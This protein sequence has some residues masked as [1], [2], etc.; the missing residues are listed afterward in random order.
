MMMMMILLLCPIIF[1]SVLFSR[2]Q[3][4]W[5][6]GMI[7]PSP[8]GLPLI[9]NLHQ[10]G[11]HTHRSLCSLSHRYGPLML[12]HLGS[13]PVLIVSSAEMAKEVL[14]THDV[15]FANRPRSK[16]SEKLLYN[17][18]DVASAPYGEYWRQMKRVCVIHLLSKKMVRSF[19]DVREEEISLMMEKIKK[20]SSGSSPFNL[21][22]ILESLTNDVICRVAL[23]QK[24]GGETDF[25]KLTDRLSELLGTFSIGSFVPWLSWIDWIRGWDAQLDKTGKDL[26][27]F[28]ERVVQDHEDDNHRDR[29]DLIDA[30]LTVKREKSAGFEIDRLS[31]KAIMLDV[32]VG[33]S[34]TSF[35]LLEWAMTELL[36]HPESMKR[37]Q[38][39]VRTICKGKSSVS[40]DDTQEM[41]YLNAVIKEALRLHP[42]FPMMAPHESTED[43]KL[44]DYHIPAGTQVMMNAWAIGREAATWGQDAE[45]FKPERHLDTSVDF[46]GQHFELLPFGAGRRICPAVSF[47]VTLNEVVLANLVHG[48]DWKLPEGSTE[49]KTDVAESSGFSVHREFSLY[50]IALPT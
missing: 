4:R 9:G 37:L 1:F 47:A 13:V 39:E 32:F 36:R 43:V 30:L 23:G 45:E 28:F 19:R 7:P 22:K 49:D 6:K 33:G 21:S 48:F 20:S 15:A 29:A 25:K 10:L 18:R 12:L 5:K 17:N 50:A 27:E 38:E 46:Q 31:I 44:R 24:Y 26:D 42:P 34:D 11:R 41:R 16:L 40:E 35:T 14:K 3:S 2:K 8:P